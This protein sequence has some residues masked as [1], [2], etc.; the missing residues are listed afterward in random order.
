VVFLLLV[1]AF[2]NN[3]TFPKSPLFKICKTMKKNLLY[4]VLLFLCFGIQ[5]QNTT[6][7]AASW[8][9][10]T[11]N[12]KD[13]NP[14]YNGVFSGIYKTGT[15]NA[16]EENPLWYKFVPQS[17]VVN[18]KVSASSCTGAAIE[19][20]LT[21]S[22]F[23]ARTP[24]C[25]DL[26]PVTNNC[27]K[28]QNGEL[29]QT[30]D[31]TLLVPNQSYYLQIDGLSG[32]QCEFDLS[33][34]STQVSAN[35]GTVRGNVLW[36]KNS[37]CQKDGNDF[38][39]KDALLVFKKSA[40]DSVFTSVDKN[41]FYEL[42]LPLGTY[43][44]YTSVGG[45]KRLWK[46]CAFSKNL[47]LSV[48]NAIV[49][50]DFLLQKE[51]DCSIIETDLIA[52][53]FVANEKTS[54][55]VKYKNIGTAKANNAIAKVSLDPSLFMVN[56]SKPFA[57]NNN[58]ITVALGNLEAQESGSFTISVKNA[59]NLTNAQA[60]VNKAEM[61]PDAVCFDNPAWT[62]GEIQI[63]A[64]CEKDS[65]RFSAQI[66][67]AVKTP[68]NGIIIEDDIMMFTKKNITTLNPK[69]SVVVFTTPATGKTY[70]LEVDQTINY[71]Q[72]SMPSVT[73]E[74]CRKGNSGSFSVGY[75]NQFSQDDAD[76][77]KDIDVRETE[78]T[79][80]SASKIASPKGVSTERYIAQNQDIE[81]FIRFK[82]KELNPVKQLYIVDTLSESMDLSTLRMGAANLPF[83]YEVTGKNLLQFKLSD[84]LIYGEQ[85][86]ADSAEFF[87]KYRISQKKDLPLGTL[88]QSRAAIFTNLAVN[89]ILTEK[90]QHKVGK[91]FLKIKVAS[92]EV[93][94]QG[95]EVAVFP[96]PFSENAEIIVKGLSNSDDL[97]T[98]QIIDNQ[99]KIIEKQ[100]QTG[101]IFAIKNNHW[102][103]GVYFYHIHN[104][105]QK[106]ASGKFIVVE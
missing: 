79:I 58:I 85:V 64:T 19:K 92:Q 68:I 16:T 4:I 28:L 14:V 81:Y 55:V 18:F 3:L 26:R 24:N 35:F 69:D 67:G 103:K 11:G 105:K 66:N 90:T 91:D 17:T 43:E 56:V 42:S 8:L 27:I 41:G 59:N 52:N 98:L 54:L 60:I 86:N 13:S 62:G 51:K 46:N 77:A 7:C 9:P 6:P 70:R 80:A 20:G 71:P 61:S 40:T 96:N 31:A 39:L 25:Q 10:Q 50:K 84:A 101:S 1:A 30:F 106:L 75:Y 95:V 82:N 72:R 33:Y 57:K 5:A 49:N 74:G 104:R 32:S 83:E 38:L 76:F 87:V 63:F 12:V 15:C 99:G 47:T 78:T 88:I 45:E 22:V 37:D 94:L 65:V 93:F 21:F 44:T 23:Q 53:A 48:P 102:A 29:N 89:L 34:P 36:D 2:A 100:E 97:L 73:V